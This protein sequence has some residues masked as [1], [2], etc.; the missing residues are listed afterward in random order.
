MSADVQLQHVIIAMNKALAGVLIHAGID[1]R[2]FVQFAKLGYVAAVEDACK[3]EGKLASISRVSRVTGLSRAE[4]K[5]LLD[6]IRSTGQL[7]A[8]TSSFEGVALHFWYTIPAFLDDEG[9]PAAIEFGPG[10]GT[11][12]DLVASY[13]GETDAGALLDRL[14]DTGCVKREADGRLRAVKRNYSDPDALGLALSGIEMMASTIAHNKLKKHE[15]SMLQRQVYSH[16]IEPSALLMIR[17]LLRD[18][19]ANFCEE[20]DDLF[21]G[22][23]LAEADEIETAEPGSLMTAGLGVYYYERPTQTSDAGLFSSG[24]PEAAT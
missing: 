4:S 21:S 8:C 18:K 16:T 13:V 12:S 20:V 6:E 24:D 23:E 14:V 22:H 9:M 1:G 2:Q 3:Q 7:P 10:D 15:P 17:R 5:R 19:A 11:F